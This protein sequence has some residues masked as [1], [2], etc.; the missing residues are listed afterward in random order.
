MLL[1]LMLLL[2][3][4]DCTDRRPG[5]SKCVEYRQDG[6]CLAVCYSAST[7]KKDGG[8]DGHTLTGHGADHAACL[9]DLEAQCAARQKR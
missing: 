4:G 5:L 1:V 6:S 7:W 9:S 2:T 3:Q 8:T